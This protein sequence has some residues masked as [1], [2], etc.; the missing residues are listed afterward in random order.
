MPM[1]DLGLTFAPTPQNAAQAPGSASTPVQEAIRTLAL[2]IPKVLGTNRGITSP[3]LMQSQG[4]AA[5][6]FSGNSGIQTGA[7]GGLEYIL[8]QIFGQRLG[9]PPGTMV[10]SLNPS[11][12][13]G[14]S[15][16]PRPY[17]YTDPPVS[18]PS[19]QPLPGV[20]FATPGETTPD[21]LPSV[22]DSPFPQRPAVGK[23]FDDW[24]ARD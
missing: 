8:Q 14:V 22:P 21:S 5:I 6:P 10:T 13:Y 17:R 19:R 4:S 7:P 11:V 9:Q 23:P 1:P 20:K 12:P 18:L 3:S 2:R 16:E 15:E 24:R